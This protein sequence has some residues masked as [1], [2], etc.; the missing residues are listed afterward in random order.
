MPKQA[1]KDTKA[2]LYT[3]VYGIPFE[4][5][6]EILLDL[7]NEL[8]RNGVPDKGKVGV[9][10]CFG[11]SLPYCNGN[12]HSI[13]AKCI[14]NSIDTAKFSKFD[15]NHNQDDNIGNMIGLKIYDDTEDLIPKTPMR[16]FGYG[17]LYR[18]SL[19]S[20]GI[21][22]SDLPE[23]STSLEV[24]FND[25]DFYYRGQVIRKEEAPVEWVEHL[26][27]M[28]EGIP[29]VVDNARVNLILGGIDEDAKVTFNGNSLLTV[30]PADEEA[31]ILLAVAQLKRGIFDKEE[32]N[33][34]TYT[35]EQLQEKVQE[36]VKKAEAKMQVII[37][38]LDGDLKTVNASLLEKDKIIAD[39]GEELAKVK[40]ELETATASL[41]TE[42]DRA[43]KAEG[44]LQKQAIATLITERK[45]VLAA[46]KYPE[47][48]IAKKEEWLGKVSKEE[49][50]E[51]LEEVDVLF[52][53]A[54]ALVQKEFQAQASAKGL[55][56]N[57]N[58]TGG[59]SQED[60]NQSK[61]VN[62]L[63]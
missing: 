20:H 44:E 58:L 2:F 22:P 17:V 19:I 23:Y 38:K 53:S 25:Y 45:Q 7:Q 47:D 26:D 62:V 18:T 50:D 28:I 16:V 29:Y 32:F 34:M 61:D 51:F 60:N 52:A 9:A 37:D 4:V 56:L 41:A 42:K 48:R 33:V 54:Q 10:L 55:D 43:D 6:N 59:G 39:V 27:D 13:T 5:D 31:G 24:L 14:K 1:E 3:S 35:E 63:L 11:R 12:G 49:F 15:F 30:R 46:K 36:E 40:G 21:Y 8:E 57:F